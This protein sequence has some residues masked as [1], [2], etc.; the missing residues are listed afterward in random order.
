MD[1]AEAKKCIALVRAAKRWSCLCVAIFLILGC[2]RYAYE[3]YVFAGFLKEK[4]MVVSIKELTCSSRVKF[5]TS[6][7]P[8]WRRTVEYPASATERR[9]ISFSNLSAF[10]PAINS[11]VDVYINPENPNDAYT[12]L[13]TSSRV[14]MLFWAALAFAAI[15]GTL[16]FAQTKYKNILSA[17]E[18]KEA[19]S[20][21]KG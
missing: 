17:L 4:G 14:F 19:E 6:Y 16:Y 7:Y 11:L 1:I 15:L 10:E 21:G 2:A 8:C 5:S 20:E 12:K 18:A 3:Q 9:Q 13:I